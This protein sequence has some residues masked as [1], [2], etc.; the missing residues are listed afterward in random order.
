ML[1]LLYPP[2]YRAAPPS[3]NLHG[4]PQSIRDGFHPLQ[5]KNLVPYGYRVLGWVFCMAPRRIILRVNTPPHRPSSPSAGSSRAAPAGT[6][7]QAH[8]VAEWVSLGSCT[9]NPYLFFVL[10]SSLSGALFSRTPTPDP[11]TW[12]QLSHSLSTSASRVESLP[13]RYTP[14]ASPFLFFLLCS[15]IVR[16]F[17]SNCTHLSTPPRKRRDRSW[18]SCAAL[19][20]PLLR[21]A[22]RIR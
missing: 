11:E 9:S 15:L 7:W 16:F 10:G 1:A 5:Q 4:H 21:P 14:G 3:K 22:A 2:R 12:D 13:Q 19:P 6:S 20:N 17:V 8:R 18:E